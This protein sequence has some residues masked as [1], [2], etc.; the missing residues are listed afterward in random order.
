MQQKSKVKSTK[1]AK[2]LENGTN[3]IGLS[4]ERILSLFVF[5]VFVL[6]VRANDKTVNHLLLL[7]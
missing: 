3:I 2:V 6:A 7:S 1:R 4:H 5:N